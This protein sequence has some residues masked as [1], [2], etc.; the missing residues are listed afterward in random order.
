MTIRELRRKH[1][2]WTWSYEK[3]GWDYIYIGVR[4][5]ERVAIARFMAEW[6]VDDGKG[7]EMY[8]SWSKP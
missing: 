4:P 8:E 3:R 1:P 2:D 6:V 5:H 7:L